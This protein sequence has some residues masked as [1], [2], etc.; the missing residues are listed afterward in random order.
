MTLQV[1]IS[2][3]CK[4]KL[5]PN[6]WVE[7]ISEVIKETTLQAEADC[8]TEAPVITGNLRRGHSSDF[9]NQLTGEIHNNMDYWV[10]VVF[11]HHR[12][13]GNNYPQR[14]LNNLKTKNFVSKSFE[15]AINK[16]GLK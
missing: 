7:C 3:P 5:T 9:P 15:K 12:Y 1:T 6:L 8:K 16:R 10:Y 11:G 14:V 13:S 2:P 4:K